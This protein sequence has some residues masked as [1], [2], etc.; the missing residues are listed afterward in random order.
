MN[1][2]DILSF[3][4][5]HG[6][7]SVTSQKEADEAKLA[8]SKAFD[9]ML[10]GVDDDLR[11][12]LNLGRSVIDSMDGVDVTLSPLGC[13]LQNFASYIVYTSNKTSLEDRRTSVFYG[14]MGGNAVHADK[15]FFQADYRDE[16]LKGGSRNDTV[17]ALAS[18][19]TDPTNSKAPKDSTLQTWAK[20]A[21]NEDN[22]ERKAG[23]KPKTM[24]SEAP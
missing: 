19:Y 23:R 21:D 2:D 3:I 6:N 9:V 12:F 13:V 22:F 14:R 1:D 4:D 17:K 15:Q 10:D 5:T 20:E 7:T 24:G 18:I 8:V 16:R 11:E